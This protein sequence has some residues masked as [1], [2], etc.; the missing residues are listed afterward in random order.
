MTDS[1]AVI[2]WPEVGQF[3]VWKS[4]LCLLRIN[5]AC[6]EAGTDPDFV[7]ATRWTPFAEEDATYIT[8]KPGNVEFLWYDTKLQRPCAIS[9]P[10]AHELLPGDVLIREDGKPL[11]IGPET[12]K[13]WVHVL[14][15]FPTTA[16]PHLYGVSVGTRT[17][18]AQ[19]QDRL[20]PHHGGQAVIAPGQL[21]THKTKLFFVSRIDFG[22]ATL[23]PVRIKDTKVLATGEAKQVPV[24][25]VLETWLPA[26]MPT[27]APRTWHEV[28]LESLDEKSA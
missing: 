22:M 16:R 11:F 5:V 12:D 19:V 28:L 26:G 23:V 24:E 17:S 15:T 25:D 6:D 4:P 10:G 27:K 20:R 3:W 13:N 2:R 8:F 21:W 1:S 14:S 7:G 18:D 9:Y